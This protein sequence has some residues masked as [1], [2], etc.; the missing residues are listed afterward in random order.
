MILKN[1]LVVMDHFFKFIPIKG[2]YSMNP[3]FSEEIIKLSSENIVKSIL[4]SNE[5]LSIFVWLPVWDR[6][7]KNIL[8]KKCK[9]KPYIGANYGEY[10]GLNILDNSGLVKYKDIICLSDMSYFDY[11]WFKIKKVA[12]TYLIVLQKAKFNKKLIDLSIK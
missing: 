10:E 11:K 12:H 1:I 5:H 2:N 3:P 6:N 7:G 8:S 9:L 4:S